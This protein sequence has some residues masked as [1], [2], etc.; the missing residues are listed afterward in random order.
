ME[1]DFM[2]W[3]SWNKMETKTILKNEDVL[4]MLKKAK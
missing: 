3:L 2:G 1:P 4:A